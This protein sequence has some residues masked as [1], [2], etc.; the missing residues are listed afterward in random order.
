MVDFH[1]GGDLQFDHADLLGL[2][3]LTAGR[4]Q[5]FVQQQVGIAPH[6]WTPHDAQDLHDSLRLTQLPQFRAWR[7]GSA[8]LKSTLQFVDPHLLGQVQ[9]QH[10][11]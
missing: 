10:L 3:P 7:E 11:Q 9:L 6:P 1:A 2:R 8:K 5:G 4:P